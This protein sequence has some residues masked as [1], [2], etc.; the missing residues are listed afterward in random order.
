MSDIFIFNQKQL[1]NGVVE[2]GPFAQPLINCCGAG[3]S[4]TIRFNDSSGIQRYNALQT[5]VV[6][7]LTRGLEFQANY[8]WSKCLSNGLGYFGQF[9]D[10]EAL[11]GTV[12]QTNSSFFFQNA[13]DPK[14]DYGR[15]ISDVASAFNG[16]LTYDLPFGHGRQFAGS[17]NK[18]VDEL[19]GGWSIATNF[20][21][22][23]GFAINPSAPDQSG[24][25]SSGATRPDC[26][27]GVSKYG[28]GQTVSLGP[29][30]VGFQFLNPA[31]VSLPAAGSFGTCSEGSFRG[32]S[33][34]TVDFGITKAF[35]I[36][37]QLRVQFM[38]QFINLTNTPIFG[39]PNA[40]FG[41]TF[42]VISS[43]NP[44]RQI[45]FA[46]KVTF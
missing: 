30:Q 9:G 34:K 18:A 5:S 13:Y 4:P 45:Q 15:C 20:T 43:S 36:T 40:G 28:N 14:G 21:L 22:H 3:N 2:P 7:H 31:A 42:G 44:G 19:I 38:S 11:P 46:L 17:V 24:T 35:T 39:A 41:S 37:E 26:V 12:S 23:S 33:L 10:E 25:N 8:T 32:P 6:Q 27:A 29:G 1:V 16:Y